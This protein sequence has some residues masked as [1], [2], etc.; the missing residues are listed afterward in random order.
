VHQKRE[1]PL[2]CCARWQ[3]ALM[4]AQASSRMAAVARVPGLQ[5]NAVDSIPAVGTRQCSYHGWC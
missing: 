3:R 2:H 4:Q 5:A 1:A